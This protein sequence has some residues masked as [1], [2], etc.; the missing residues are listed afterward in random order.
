[1]VRLWR[2]AVAAH[3]RTPAYLVETDEGVRAYANGLLARGVRKGDTFG[4]L[5]HN[6]LQWALL[7]FALAH[8]GAVSVPIYATSS[9]RDVQY[10]LEHSEAVGV[11]CGDADQLAKVEAERA[12]LPR[13]EHVLGF[14]AL[15]EFAA[16]GRD[17]ERE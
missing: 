14:P 6:S 12:H 13:L 15:E 3:R 17:Y 5:A 16:E 9:A 2:N 7:D 8:I 1:M 4:V 11:V 10:L